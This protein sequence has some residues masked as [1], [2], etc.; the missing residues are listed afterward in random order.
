MGALARAFGHELYRARA[1]FAHRAGATRACCAG[2]AATLSSEPTGDIARNVE[3][4][5][6]TSIELWPHAP[7]PS[8]SSY[9]DLR[10]NEQ[11]YMRDALRLDHVLLLPMSSS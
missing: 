7:L 1:E 5:L 8:K 6:D 2:A 3:H 11:S 9:T 4:A 10:T